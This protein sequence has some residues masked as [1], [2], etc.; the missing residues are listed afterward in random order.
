MSNRELAKTARTFGHETNFIV[1]SATRDEAYQANNTYDSSV[2]EVFRRTSRAP[3][4]R[5]GG[6]SRADGPHN[7]QSRINSRAGSS[8]Q[9]LCPKCNR[10][11]HRKRPCPALKLKCNECGK[12]GHFAVVCTKNR[13]NAIEDVSSQDAKLEAKEEEVNK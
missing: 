13:I 2:N 6:F 4:K 5:D 1:Q 3:V 12:F 9:E 8:R 11:M 7:K 10:W